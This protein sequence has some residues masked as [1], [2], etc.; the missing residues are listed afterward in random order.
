MPQSILHVVFND[1][2]GGVLKQALRMSGRSEDKIVSCPDCL[3]FGPINPPDIQARVNWVKKELY[4]NGEYE[5][6]IQEAESFWQTAAPREETKVL[7]F[8]RYNTGEYAGFLEFLWQLKDTPCLIADVTDAP[9]MTSG[10]TDRPPREV[11]ALTLGFLNPEMVVKNNILN[12]SRAITAEERERYHRA[13]K[14]LRDENAPFRIARTD[15]LHSAPITCFDK[16]VL[17]CVRN[18]WLKSARVIGDALVKDEEFM[19]AGD[20]V[21]FARL[22]KLVEQGIVESQGDMS[23]MR[24]SEVRLPQTA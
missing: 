1:S 3:S 11:R 14:R 5:E 7:W 23:Q 17:S 22:R 19:Q 18:K 12:L 6:I 10:S 21:L 15:G 9:V 20:L 8:S 2:A 4:D 13:W 24:F 16:L